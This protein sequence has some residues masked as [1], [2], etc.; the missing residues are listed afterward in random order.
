MDYAEEGMTKKVTVDHAARFICAIDGGGMAGLK[1]LGYKVDKTNQEE[2]V[3]ALLSLEASLI[4]TIPEDKRRGM[5][6]GLGFMEHALCKLKRLDVKEFH[7][8]RDSLSK[9]Y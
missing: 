2:V 8:W 1:A 6:F 9:K 7:N 5:E 3:K 4:E